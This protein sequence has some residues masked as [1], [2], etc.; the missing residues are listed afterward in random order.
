MEPLFL[1][2]QRTPLYPQIARKIALLDKD[3]MERIQKWR[4]F[5]ALWELEI[6]DFYGKK[7]SYRGIKYAGSPERVFWGYFQPFFEHEIPRDF[8]IS[9]SNVLVK[10]YPL[11][12][13]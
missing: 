13:F 1:T 4:M 3:I 8:P 2:G 6:E 11:K 10:T 9:N 5:S 7:I 12:I